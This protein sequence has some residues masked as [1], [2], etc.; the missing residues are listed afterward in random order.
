MFPLLS[1]YLHLLHLPTCLFIQCKQTGH[2][3]RK[4]AI[5]DLSKRARILVCSDDVEDFCADLCVA[6]DAHGV[7]IG[8]KHWS[9]IIE[10]FYLDVH[11]G[12]STQ[13]SLQVKKG[14]KKEFYC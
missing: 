1:L 14:D 10:V 3:T 8:V 4:D 5:C 6:A 13:A 2:V 11:V 9:V 7:L 12:L